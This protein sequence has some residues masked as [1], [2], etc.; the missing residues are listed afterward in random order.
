VV[1]LLRSIWNG[2]VRFALAHTVIEDDGHRIAACVRPGH[3]YAHVGRDGNGRY[4]DRWVTDDPAVPDSWARTRVLWLIERGPAH[5][6][7]LFWDDATDAFLGWYVQLQAPVAPSRFGFD[8][9]DH[10]L[11]VWV[12]PDGSW[13]WKDEVDLA[14]AI[15]LGVFDEAKA[16]AI[17][18]EGERVVAAA[19]WPTGW[20]DWRPDPSWAVPSLPH[21]WDRV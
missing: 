13:E 11:D 2:R 6:L 5:S 16:A 8:A 15:E 1:V 14:D 3:G 20:E 7:G 17:R 4:L 21:G 18:A 12:N 19:P 10:A 9:T